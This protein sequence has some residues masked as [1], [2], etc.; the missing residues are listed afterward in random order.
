MGKDLSASEQELRDRESELREVQRIAMVGGV[1][2]DLRDGF[3]NRRSAEYLTIHGLPPE[4]AN[5]THEDWVARLH[6]EDRE[7]AERQFFDLLKSDADRYSS[8]YRI[9]R[10]SDGEVRWIVAAARIERDADGRP[11]RMVGAH[12]D[13]TERALAKEALRESE[14]RFR[15]VA[16]SAPVPMWV[17]RLDQTRSFANKAWSFWASTTTRG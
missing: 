16:D 4:A 2:V 13:I 7:R 6:P 5:E 14:E 11:L 1:V 17:T 9:V 15:L 3:K 8:E 12:I 10:P